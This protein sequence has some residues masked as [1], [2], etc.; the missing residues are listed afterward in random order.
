MRRWSL[1]SFLSFRVPVLSAFVGIVFARALAAGVVINEIYYDHPGADDG[2][3]FVELHNPDTVSCV[4]T[5]WALQTLDGATGAAKVVWTASPGA[6]LEPGGFLC[7]A[8]IE[9]APAAGLLLRGTLGNGPD[10]IRLVSPAGTADLVGYGACASGDLYEGAPAPDV[11]AG[12]CLARKP[13]G[14]DSGRNDADFVAAP[15]TPGRRNFFRFDIGMSLVPEGALPCGGALFSLK[16]RI[17]NCGLEAARG[18]VSILSGVS[19][20]G[21][22]GFTGARRH[23]FDLAVS[24]ADSIDLVLAAPEAP[25]FEVRARFDGAV[26]ENA[27]ND[28]FRALLGSSPGAVVVNEIMYRPEREMSEWIEI[29]NG[30]DAACNLKG[31]TICD[32]TGARRLVSSADAILPP[33]SFSILAKDSASFARQYPSCAASVRAVEGG[34]PSLND[35]DRGERADAVSLFDESGVLVETVSYRDLLGDERGRSIERISTGACSARPGGIWHRC[36]AKRRATPGSENSTRVGQTPRSR[37]LSVSPN[38]FSPRRDGEVM[39]A[40][41][42][43]AGETGFLARIF[44][45]EGYE[46]RRLFGESGGADVFACRW[47]GR[48]SDGRSAR[49]GLYI[50]LVEY[51]GAGGAICR[52]E[53]ACIVVAGD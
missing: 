36:A 16:V 18:S 19:A 21:T 52:R 48:T 23:S 11:P 20:A 2:W 37:G 49:T 46:V 39:V 1:F 53:K 6:S 22:A 3:E 33:R 44:D 26:D 31:W 4:L 45:R 40:G 43:E 8:G 5:G 28:S 15:P 51:A 17:A 14:G 41:A 9:R 27:A 29:A 30:S 10:A 50:C 32:A 47:D 25:R 42:R 24:A 35:T 13:D 38:P 7:V 34:W 12:S